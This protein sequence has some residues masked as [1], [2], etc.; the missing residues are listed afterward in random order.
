MELSQELAQLAQ[1]SW[2]SA[3]PER[4]LPLVLFAQEQRRL[5]SQ[6][7]KTRRSE[8]LLFPDLPCWRSAARSARFPPGLGRVHS[9]AHHRRCF[10]RSASLHRRL[11]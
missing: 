3:R 4:T 6:A 7:E 2:L 9:S 10:W 5:Q 11:T 1:V 8:Q